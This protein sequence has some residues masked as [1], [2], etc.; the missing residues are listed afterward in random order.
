LRP[1]IADVFCG[2]GLVYDGL[3][4]AGWQPIGF[5]IVDQPN[6][7]GPFVQV[8]FLD[9][10]RFRGFPALWFSPP[11][12]KDTELHESA[13][14]E[15]LAHGIAPTVH[16]DLITPTQALVDELG[17]P[18]VIENVRKC[19]LLRSPLILCGSM[20][21]LGAT[22]N[23]QRYHLERH[24][25]FEVNWP[26]EVPACSHQKPV[27][28][29]YGGHARIRSASAGGRKT[30]DPWSGRGVDIMHEAMGVSRRYT[31][32]ALSQGIPP[33]YAEFIGRQL[34]AHVQGRTA[35]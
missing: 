23:G 35:P 2:S 3:Y 4:A 9:V 14:R 15:Q 22:D 20:F 28:G 30:R 27:V 25:K 8:D 33:I 34:L 13:R 5:D 24:R 7:P 32:D 1:L 19:Q 17:V 29:V 12:L 10:K 6:Y 26:L 21:G 16:P 18:Y 11:C 31:V